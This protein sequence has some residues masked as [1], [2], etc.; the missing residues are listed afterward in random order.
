MPR[1]HAVLWLI[2]L[3]LVL[4]AAPPEDAV[5]VV[6]RTLDA[7]LAIARDDASHDENLAALRSVTR[8][9]LDTRT[10]GRRAIGDVL[11]AQPPEQQAEYFD[12]FDQVMV[13]AYLSKLLLFRSPRF[14][15]GD[16]RPTGD[17]VVVPTRIETV[18]DEYRVEYVMRERDGRWLATDVVV[19]GISLTDNYR[20]QFASLLRDRSFSELLDLMRAKVRPPRVQPG[21]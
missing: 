15:Y 17:A 1:R 16:P 18:K 12:L 5:G 2:A 10:M 3:A 9:I 11:A 7:A 19:E 6:R 13:R 8:G 21:P 14:T 4:G 20:S